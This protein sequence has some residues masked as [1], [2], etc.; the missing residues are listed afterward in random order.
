VFLC[1]GEY[2]RRQWKYLK[3]MKVVA[4]GN[5]DMVEGVVFLCVRAKE[6][7]RPTSLCFY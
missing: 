7:V 3:R 2:D 1:F 4:K 6:E 5:Q